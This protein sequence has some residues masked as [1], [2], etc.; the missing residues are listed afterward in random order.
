MRVKIKGNWQDADLENMEK[1]DIME[2]IVD[3]EEEHDQI[4]CQLDD[5]KSTAADAGKYADNQWFRRAQR[6][7]K[8][9]VR[10]VQRCQIE[11]SRRK[12]ILTGLPGLFMDVCE[13]EFEP[14]EF[15]ELK[16]LALA[17]MNTAK[18]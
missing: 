1:E 14:Q 10:N 8:I 9:I 13:E 18:D 2:L 15:E 16:Q 4:Q 7:A 3:L 12:H 6:A 11:L 17:R 5:A